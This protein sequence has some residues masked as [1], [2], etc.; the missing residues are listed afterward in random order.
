MRELIDAYV[1]ELKFQ[2]IPKTLYYKRKI[3]MDFHS[4]CPKP[5]VQ[6]TKTDILDWLGTFSGS[7]LEPST[8]KKFIGL[9]KGF[10]KYCL[11]E[12]FID[13]DVTKNVKY[14]KVTNPPPRYLEPREMVLL[15]EYVSN[16]P[17]ERAIVE[18]LF[19]TGIRVSELCRMRVENI[20]FEDRFIL[21][22]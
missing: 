16:N 19:A 1:S 3:L 20:N 6:I 15:R 4:Y 2:Q 18:V 9:L 8:V 21:I 14:L 12:G 5:V 17:K 13:H 7:S 22:E 10:F 11:E